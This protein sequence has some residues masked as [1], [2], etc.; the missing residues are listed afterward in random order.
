MGASCPKSCISV[1]AKAEAG[2][3]KQDA[4]ED[5]SEPGPKVQIFCIREGGMGED[6]RPVVSDHS[7]G[8]PRQQSRGLFQ[9]REKG[10]RIRHA[11]AAVIRVHSDLEHRG[12]LRVCRP[13]GGLQKMRSR[14]GRKAS[15]G[16]GE[17]DVNDDLYAISGAL[18][19]EAVVER[20]SRIVSDNL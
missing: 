17:E 15:L 4:I 9:V 5:Y 13:P 3:G 11:A 2:G 14:A 18:G 16:V 20:G 12:V 8:G 1:F 6:R 19:A 10:A 7:G